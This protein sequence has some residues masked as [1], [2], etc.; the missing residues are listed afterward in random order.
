MTIF[1]IA[2]FFSAVLGFWL[3]EEL[4]ELV[5]GPAVCGEVMWGGC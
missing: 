1:W 4:V 5:D 2:Q 3:V